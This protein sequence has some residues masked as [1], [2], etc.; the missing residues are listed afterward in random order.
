MIKGV[1]ICQCIFALLI[2]ARFAVCA[3]I[4]L[5]PGFEEGTGIPPPPWITFGG[6][7]DAAFAVETDPSKAHSG[8]RC[9]SVSN[10]PGNVMG[11][12][13]GLKQWDVP[14]DTTGKTKYRFK[15]WIQKTQRLQCAV[16]WQAL[17]KYGVVVGLESNYGSWDRN[18]PSGWVEISNGADAILFSAKIKSVSLSVYVQPYSPTNT[19]T[20][21]IDD[22]GIYSE[23]SMTEFSSIK[24]RITYDGVPI[25]GAVVGVKASAV[26]AAGALLYTTADAD[27]NYTAYVPDGTWYVAAWREGWSPSADQTAAVSGGSAA[28][29]DLALPGIAGKNLALSTA[30]RRTAAAA[31]SAAPGKPAASAIDGDPAACWSSNGG[32]DQTLTLDL[33]PDGGRTFNVTGLT[34]Y[35]GTAYASNYTVEVTTDWPDPSGGSWT[36]VYSAAGPDSGYQDWSGNAALIVDPIRFAT[37]LPVRGVRVH[38]TKFKDTSTTSYSIGEIKVHSADE[39]DSLIYGYIR[40]GSGEPI[41]DATVYLSSVPRQLTFTDSSGFYSFGA[42]GGSYV[43]TADALGYENADSVVALT[44]GSAVARDVVLPAKPGE[45][46]L[47]PNWDFEEPDPLDPSMP[48]YWTGR[49]DDPQGQITFSRFT[50]ANHT[51]GGAA[52]GGIDYRK[53]T[54]AG[55]EWKWAGWNSA[56]FAIRSDG[57]VYNVWIW[58]TVDWYEGY[59]NTHRVVWYA[60]DGATVLRED[61]MWD[62]G[63][64][65]WNARWRWWRA[66]DYRLA[67]PEGA[68]YMA[69]RDIGTSMWFPHNAAVGFLPINAIDDVVVEEVNLAEPPDNRI[70]SAKNLSPGTRVSLVAKRLTILA[71]SSIP[72]GGGIPPDTGY[73]E[74]PDRSSGIRLDVSGWVGDTRVGPGDAVTVSGTLRANAAGEPYIAVDLVYR[75]AQTRPLDALGMNDRA[76]SGPASRGLFV[77]LCGTVA[78]NGDGYFTIDDGSGTPIKV[79]CGSLAQPSLHQFVRVRG[80][81]ST[82]GGSAVLLMRNEAVDWVA[83]DSILHPLPLPGPAKAL[84][85]YLFVGPFGDDAT[86]PATQLTTDY[87]SAA[88]GGAWTESTIRPCLGD[89]V[90]S[91]TWFRHDGVDE[92]VDLKRLFG[93]PTDRRTVYAHLY[94]Y[95]PTAQAVDVPVGFDDGI[96]VWVNGVQALSSYAPGGARYGQDCAAGVQLDPGLNSVLIKIVNDTGNFSLVTQFVMAG[97]WTAQGTLWEPAAVAG[98]GYALNRTP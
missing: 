24:G 89:S 23:P 48:R 90:G 79:M 60:A 87:I 35:W 27:G 22:C 3:N 44:D 19:G 43:F 70:G 55:D 73:I 9:F 92:L 93:A 76:A 67:P 81:L 96:A 26:A 97:S 54:S 49:E 91:K 25:P 94:V 80:V 68:A 5:N 21:Y 11:G 1:V 6:G 39:S 78:D 46:S 85:D 10:P 86:N 20:V 53:A 95:S 59:H 42:P 13:N 56:L 8:S 37:A 34:I 64:G 71:S 57:C 66:G 51:P 36:L 41:G 65:R 4:L 31:T 14:I 82:E 16:R 84:R 63:W 47:V 28:A 58:R 83:G 61:S 17:D 2:P 69:L 30:S 18:A 15:A 72:A 12:T 38:C 45:A 98:I 62:Y 50:I 74:E 32:E 40:N 52:C 77:K 33:D 88:T 7:I 29:V 75:N